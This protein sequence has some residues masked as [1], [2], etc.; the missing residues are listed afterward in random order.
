MS[1]HSDPEWR[2]LVLD[3]AMTR[4][5]RAAANGRDYRISVFA[6]DAAPPPGGFPSLIV[7][8]GSALFATVAETANR[9]SRRPEAT[10]VQPAVIIGV[11]HHGEGLYDLAQRHRDFTP[12]PAAAE[13]TPHETG[14]ADRFL[15]FLIDELLPLV[16]QTVPLDPTRRALVGHSLAGLFTLHAL[17]SR[18]AAFA[19]YGAI[20][21][22]I[23]WDREGVTQAISGLNDRSPLLFLA[24][25]ERE[26]T[27]P[28]ARHSERMMVE[29]VEELAVIAAP[30]IETTLNIFPDE[31]HGSIVSVAVTRFLRFCGTDDWR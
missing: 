28:G 23:W 13:A 16:A 25:G 11:G 7:L 8:D 14:G 19:A 15:A 30:L 26:R 17:A 6:P 18:P 24:A 9:L 21:P 20:S 12:G 1:S 2:P 22:S 10:G 31:D 27:P 4:T 5:V 3:R 29:S